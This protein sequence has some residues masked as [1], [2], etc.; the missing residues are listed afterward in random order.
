MDRSPSKGLRQRLELASIVGCHCQCQSI[1]E[2]F[3]TQHME[4]SPDLIPLHLRKELD[5]RQG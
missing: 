3:S 5:C 2:R 4:A 1:K